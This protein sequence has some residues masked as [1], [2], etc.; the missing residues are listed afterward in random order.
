[1]TVLKYK[2]L[3]IR[4]TIYKTTLTK[5]FINRKFWKQPNPKEVISFLPG[6]VMKIYVEEGQKVKEGDLLFVFEAMKME[7]IVKIPHDGTIK[8]IHTKEGDR[9][10]KG[11]LLFEYE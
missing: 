11:M 2:A 8:S 9:F 1:M 3:N 5:K 6:T 4:G 10:P 7:N